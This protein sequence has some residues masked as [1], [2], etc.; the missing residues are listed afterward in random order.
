MPICSRT[1]PP[2]QRQPYTIRSS[3]LWTKR[4]SKRSSSTKETFATTPR[5]NFMHISSASAVTLSSKFRSKNRTSRHSEERPICICP[6]RR[7]IFW[8]FA[9]NV[10]MQEV[11]QAPHWNSR[12]GRKR[13]RW[14]ITSVVM[15]VVILFI[16]TKHQIFLKIFWL[17]QVTDDTVKKTSKK[18]W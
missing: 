5:Q 13:N 8:G 15:C 12:D 11:Q 6:K 3:C 1:C 16:S 9:E 14:H 4:Q 7:Y 2:S 10:R 18:F 17:K